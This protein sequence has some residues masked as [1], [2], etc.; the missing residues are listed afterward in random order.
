MYSDVICVSTGVNAYAH[1]SI[2]SRS[3]TR[4]LQSRSELTLKR[5]QDA[6]NYQPLLILFKWLDQVLLTTL[7]RL[8]YYQSDLSLKEFVFKTSFS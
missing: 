8:L 4:Y 5:Y 2:T 6:R 7:W 1:A 3:V